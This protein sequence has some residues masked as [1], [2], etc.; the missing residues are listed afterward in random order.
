MIE[1][2]FFKIYLRLVNYDNFWVRDGCRK[3]IEY[4][5]CNLYMYFRGRLLSFRSIVV[6]YDIEIG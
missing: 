6:V 4:Y 1:L 3:D 2:S 5:I